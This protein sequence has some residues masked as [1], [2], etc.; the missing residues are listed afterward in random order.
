MSFFSIIIIIIYKYYK[1]Y[2]DVSQFLVHEK[3]SFVYLKFL[4]KYL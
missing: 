2:Y 1:A 4:N 3:H